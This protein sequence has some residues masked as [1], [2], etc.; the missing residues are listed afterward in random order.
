MSLR[1]IR[2]LRRD[3]RYLY[4]SSFRQ[5]RTVQS[6]IFLSM[7]ASNL[8][9]FTAND[10]SVSRNEPIALTMLRLSLSVSRRG[11]SLLL[12]RRSFCVERMGNL[13]C[14]YTFDLE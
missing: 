13:A 6:E 7:P 10:P 11:R 5:R 9:R 3:C 2:P 4:P 14:K 8:N 1:D 12:S